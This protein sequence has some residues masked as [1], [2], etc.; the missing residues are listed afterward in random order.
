MEVTL[1]QLVRTADVSIKIASEIV[2]VRIETFC[3]RPDVFK[4]RIFRY[5]SFR[6]QSSF[7][8]AEG[9]PVHAP[10]DEVILKELES[11]FPKF[12]K[13]QA[14]E[15]V[16]RVEEATMEELRLWCESLAP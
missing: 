16:E 13:P 4:V 11:F 15:S 5:E 12:G 14:A 2:E 1:F 8:Q 6:I 10:S 9:Q 3:R 7:P